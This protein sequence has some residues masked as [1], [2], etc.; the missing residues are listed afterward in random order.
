MKPIGILLFAVMTAILPRSPLLAADG[1]SLSATEQ[2]GKFLFFDPGLSVP[3]GQS[4][5]ACHGPEVGFTGPDEELNKGG[6]VYEGQSRGGSGTG[7]R[8][9]PP[10]R[11][12]APFYTSTG[13]K[14]SGWAACSGTGGQPGNG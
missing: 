2:L 6:A 9:L 12:T 11:E 14:E 8:L 5:A 10:T 13:K 7:S 1:A 4:C 3:E